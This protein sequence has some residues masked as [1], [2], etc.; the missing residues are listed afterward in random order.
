MGNKSIENKKIENKCHANTTICFCIRCN[1]R[2]A[3]R[4][5]IKNI[6]PKSIIM[7]S[8]NHKKASFWNIYFDEV[9]VIYTKNKIT[10]SY[11]TNQEC[12]IHAYSENSKKMQFIQIWSFNLRERRSEKEFLSFNGMIDGFINTQLFMSIYVRANRMRIYPSLKIFKIREREEIHRI[13]LS[14]LH[15]DK[16]MKHYKSTEI[17]CKYTV[18]PFI[19]YLDK[20][21]YLLDNKK[22]II[23]IQ[24]IPNAICFGEK[25][26]LIAFPN[27]LTIAYYDSDVNIVLRTSR[28]LNISEIIEFSPSLY[29][30]ADKL[31]NVFFGFDLKLHTCFYLGKGGFDVARLHKDYIS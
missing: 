7:S 29:I 25:L 12:F 21:Y 11:L 10:Q 18:S 24:D 22:I 26:K 6:R 15:V 30:F 5:Y 17:Y 19:I 28:K 31:S 14:N 23:G 2:R 13:R 1:R 9:C 20:S 27:K 16:W 4:K 3:I 8:V